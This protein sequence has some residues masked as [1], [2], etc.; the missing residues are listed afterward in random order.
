MRQ[1]RE[2]VRKDLGLAMGG[3]L[4]GFLLP[5]VLNQVKGIGPLVGLVIGGPFTLGV[6]GFWLSFV[7]GEGADIPRLFDGFKRFSPALVAYLLLILWV[8]L[9]TLLLIVPGILKGLSL[10][11]TFYLMNDR[12]H[13]KPQEA[14]AL[15]TTWMKGYRGRLFGLMVRWIPWVLLSILTLGILLLWILP[16]MY[17]SYALFYQNLK[18]L[19]E[20]EEPSV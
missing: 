4:L 15:S 19:R 10:S 11:Q 20:S 9:W 8:L 5:G 13:L 3:A 12:P 14:L 16:R 1:A 7:R 17:A 6:T 18:A 2:L